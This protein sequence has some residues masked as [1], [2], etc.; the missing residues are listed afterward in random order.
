VELWRTSSISI[1]LITAFLV[2]IGIVTWQFAR[3][4]GKNSTLKEEEKSRRWELFLKGFGSLTVVVAGLLA[5]LRYFDQR[6]RELAQQVDEQAQKTRQ[7]NLEI[8]GRS[9]DLAQ[10]KRVFLNEAVDLAATLATLE[11]LDT[12]EGVIAGNR[13]ERLYHGQLVLYES[14]PVETAMIDFR[15]ALLK[16]KRTQRKPTELR[17]DERSN[18][19]EPLVLEKQ[20]S[21]FMRRLALRLSAACHDELKDAEGAK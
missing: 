14:K 21:D 6:E 9:T 18:S 15:D 3:W 2:A 4:V 5:F 20:N 7:F 1:I 13:L 12:P 11:N 16:W 10:A 19:S 8:Y 17:A